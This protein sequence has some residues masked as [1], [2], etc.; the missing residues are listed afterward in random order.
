MD[1]QPHQLQVLKLHK[2]IQIQL[3]HLWM[4]HQLQ[5]KQQK[6]R[7]QAQAANNAITITQDKHLL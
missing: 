6:H 5:H 2:Q 7:T 4:G 1:K 3:Q